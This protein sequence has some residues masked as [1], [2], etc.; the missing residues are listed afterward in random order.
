MGNRTIY[1]CQDCK[2]DNP[3]GSKKCNRCGRSFW[4]GLFQQTSHYDLRW[5]C[6]RCGAINMYENKRCWG[7]ENKR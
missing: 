7:C 2:F 5:A 6:E 4:T 3:S 1:T